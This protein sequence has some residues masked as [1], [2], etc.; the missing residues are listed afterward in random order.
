M[1]TF[2]LFH[3]KRQHTIFF[4]Q[5]FDIIER[6]YGIQPVMAASEL[7]NSTIPDASLL[8]SYVSQIYDTFRGEIPH[9]GMCL[10]SSLLLFGHQ[11]ISFI[12]SVIYTHPLFFTRGGYYRLIP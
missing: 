12:L 6:E 9:V 8:I 7:A 2:N 3:T 11:V 5:V 1:L 10:R 4:P